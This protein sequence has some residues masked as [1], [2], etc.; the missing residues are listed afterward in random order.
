MKLDIYLRFLGKV[1]MWRAA[2]YSEMQ[3]ERD[4]SKESLNKSNQ[5]LNIWKILILSTLSKT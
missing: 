4:K 2:A 1:C 3:E 5:N